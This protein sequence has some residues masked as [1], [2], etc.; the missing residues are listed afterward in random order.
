[1]FLAHVLALLL[2][3]FRSSVLAF[4]EARELRRRMSRRYPRIED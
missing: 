3:F 1:M 4:S 2:R